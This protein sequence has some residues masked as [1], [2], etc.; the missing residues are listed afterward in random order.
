MHRLD[1]SAGPLQLSEL[2]LERTGRERPEVQGP[3]KDLMAECEDKLASL[4]LMAES[5]RN[6][7]GWTSVLAHS[8]AQASERSLV[9]ALQDRVVEL[10]NMVERL[11]SQVS[12]EIWVVCFSF[13]KC[14]SSRER[15]TIRNNLR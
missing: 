5:V 11:R 13:T 4:E 3:R 12:R 7:V 1:G 9:L 6:S 8:Q 10:E 15:L 14:C 2:A